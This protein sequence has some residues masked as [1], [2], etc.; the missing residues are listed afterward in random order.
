MLTEGKRVF[1]YQGWVSGRAIRMR[2]PQTVR[3]IER[4]HKAFP[5][6][7]EHR[8][9]LAAMG[10]D[11]TY[12]RFDDRSGVWEATIGL[13]EGVAK[14][15]G[16]TR[17]VIVAYLPFSQ[18][19][20]RQ[21]ERVQQTSIPDRATEEHVAFICSK[22]PLENDKLTDWSIRGA[23]QLIS[24]PQYGT[25]E[26]IANAIC[27][28]LIRSLS[29]RNAY[30]VSNAVIGDDFFGREKVINNLRRDLKD[31]YVAGVFGLRKVGK[32]SIVKEVMRKYDAASSRD[33]RIV[34]LIEDLERLPSALEQRVP[35]LCESLAE[36]LRIEFKAQGLR[37]HEISRFS[38]DVARGARA[39][40]NRLRDAI[41]ATLAHGTSGDA[42]MVLGF[43]EVESL[44][45][46]SEGPVREAPEVAEFLGVL[47]SLTQE[48]QNFKV[49]LAGITSAPFRQDQIYGRENPLF[50][51]AKPAYIGPLEKQEADTMI[52][53]LG[54]RMAV[55]WHL[56][57]LDELFKVTSGHAFLHRNL[58]A[59][60]VET[61]LNVERPSGGGRL[62][63]PGDVTMRVRAWRREASEVVDGMLKA[64]ERYY[65]DGWE[66]IR[67]LS[68]GY[69]LT[70]I[71]DDYP[72][73]V[74]TLLNLGVLVEVKGELGVS[75]WAKTSTLLRNLA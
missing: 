7:R 31:G 18:V 36:S 24:M 69:S 2:D 48:H 10:S 11:F 19:Y 23:M 25:V 70:D 22:D 61:V 67:H 5:I 37:T 52:T 20:D 12:A 51:W 17:N 16:I 59:A 66:A 6:S 53:R 28:S 38:E 54:R 34:T 60:V 42:V 35:R 73:A 45:A 29:A 8:A 9:A 1:G 33:V 43:D 58:A 65:P 30:D 50:S 57:A 32:T 63:L 4:M 47:R 21:L 72:A 13:N 46:A 44:I 64:L 71:D 68:D 3:Y 56:G 74:A 14:R 75:P 49:I 40:P 62:V 41:H 26:D 55:E 39:E 27:D 15:L